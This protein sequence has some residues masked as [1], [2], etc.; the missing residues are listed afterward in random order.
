MGRHGRDYAVHRL[1][2]EYNDRQT[3]HDSG[4][5]AAAPVKLYEAALRESRDYKAHLVKVR[6]KE[7]FRAGAV[8]GS[9]HIAAA[10][11]LNAVDVRRQ[12]FYCHCRGPRLQTGHARRHCQLL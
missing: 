9:D 7:Y 2:A 10:V 5:R 3:G 6:V 1:L 11:R 12:Q 8:Y 4:V